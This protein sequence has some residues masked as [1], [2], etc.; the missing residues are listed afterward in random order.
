M[1]GNLPQKDNVLYLMTICGVNINRLTNNDEA[2]YNYF[3]RVNGDYTVVIGNTACFIKI[4][5]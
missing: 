3:H 1:C 4:K 2:L 5:Y